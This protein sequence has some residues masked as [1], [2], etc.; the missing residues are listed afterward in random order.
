[1][2]E[3]QLYKE[4]LEKMRQAMEEQVLRSSKTQVPSDLF[5]LLL[6]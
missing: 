4:K 2:E 1:M 3:S 6:M 5:E